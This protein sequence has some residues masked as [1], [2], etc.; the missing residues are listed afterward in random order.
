MTEPVKTKWIT[1]ANHKG[2]CGKTTTVVNLAAEFARMGLSVLV[3]DLD[4]QANASMHIGKLHP[5]EVALTS[6]E[7]LSDDQVNLLDAIHEDTNLSGVSLIYGSLELGR[8]E[9]NLKENTA[10][11]AEELRT[12]LEPLE[13]IYDVVLIDCPPSLK[14]LTSNALSVATQLIIPIESGSQ[15]GLYGVTD[16]LRHVEKIRRIN[17]RLDFMGALLIKHD[18]RQTVCRL[19]ETAA[20][21]QLGKVFPIRIPVSTKVN[22]AAMAQMSLYDIDKNAKV[23]KEFAD[24]AR[25]IATELRM[26][27]VKG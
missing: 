5:S 10:R 1:V 22:Q 7:L 26:N 8:A 27:W 24:L 6:A 17:P 25:Y 18:E 23:S 15:Y 21:E 13:G 19:I 4:P 9:D 12:K 2:G 20:T 11:P 16:L 14:L 3:V